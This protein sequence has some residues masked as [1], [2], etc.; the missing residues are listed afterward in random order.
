MDAFCVP[1]CELWPSDPPRE[2]LYCAGPLLSHPLVSP[3]T[4]SDWTGACPVYMFIGGGERSNADARFLAKQMSDS[5]V[6]VRWQEYEAMPHLW[7]FVFHEWVATKRCWENWG[8]ACAELISGEV[9]G[10]SAARVIR[11]PDGKAETVDLGRLTELSMED[12]R[13]FLREFQRKQKPFLGRQEG[14]SSL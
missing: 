1:P 13:G 2:N 3:I 5:G 9:D 11:V 4:A 12:V 8:K 14:R 7:P 6:R 10:P